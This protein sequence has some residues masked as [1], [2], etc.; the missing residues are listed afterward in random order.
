MVATM[1]ENELNHLERE[2]REAKEELVRRERE[3]GT[4]G[5][6]APRRV[7][8]QHLTQLGPEEL[9][10]HVERLERDIKDLKY[11]EAWPPNDVKKDL[12]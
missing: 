10:D 11:A 5:M 3:G 7:E 6:I 2:L 9:E 4:K 12:Q 8:F 1:N